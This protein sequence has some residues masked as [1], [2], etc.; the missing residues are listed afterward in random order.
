VL[1]STLAIGAGVVLIV[2]PEPAT[3]ALGLPL[4]FVGL[5]TRPV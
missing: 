4:V 5:L 2:F 3:S 1:A